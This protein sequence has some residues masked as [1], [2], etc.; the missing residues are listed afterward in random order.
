MQ[1]IFGA[2][3]NNNLQKVKDLIENKASTPDELEPE[4]FLGKESN[5][6]T[7]ENRKTALEVAKSLGRHEIVGYLT[8]QKELPQN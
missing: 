1:T 3:I 8:S 2:I 5:V 6:H 7:R 4:V